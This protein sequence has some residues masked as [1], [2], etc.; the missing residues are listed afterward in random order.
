MEDIDAVFD[1]IPGPT[2]PETARDQIRQAL[3]RSSPWAVAKEVGRAYVPPGAPSEACANLLKELRKIGLYVVE[4]GELESFAR[5]V[6]GHG[7]RWV[8]DVLSKDLAKD[9]ELAPARQFVQSII[10]RL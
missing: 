7:P 4:V 2:V 1:S 8:N 3:R 6:G 9:A 5:T 10:D